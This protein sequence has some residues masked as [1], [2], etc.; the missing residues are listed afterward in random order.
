MFQDMNDRPRI[1]NERGRKVLADPRTHRYYV[2]L[3][4]E[5][6]LRFLSLYEQSGLRTK[7]DFI[8]ARIFG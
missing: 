1:K 2:R 3:N 8:L 5:Q 4:D 7:A 6:N